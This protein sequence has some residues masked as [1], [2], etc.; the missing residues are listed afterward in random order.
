M[1]TTRTI[2]LSLTL[3]ASIGGASRNLDADTSVSTVIEVTKFRGMTL[4]DLQISPDGGE[5]AVVMGWGSSTKS[6]V[7]RIGTLN[8]DQTSADAS[9]E[10]GNIDTASERVVWTSQ[11]EIVVSANGSVV[12]VRREKDGWARKKSQLANASRI[13]VIDS[14]SMIICDN[15]ARTVRRVDTSKPGDVWRTQI[16]HDGSGGLSLDETGSRILVYSFM[17][18]KVSV[19]DAAT[20]SLLTSVRYTDELKP[21]A[22]AIVGKGTILSIDAVGRWACHDAAGAAIHDGRLQAE[23]LMVDGSAMRSWGSTFRC[24]F[25]NE[26]KTRVLNCSLKDGQI[27]Q[28]L[29]AE[30]DGKGVLADTT[31]ELTVVL[32]DQGSNMYSVVCMRAR[33]D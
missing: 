9:V 17:K 12:T 6:S 18:D 22:T 7:L 27:E 30:I 33:T 24:V 29:I 21:R 8:P 25:E 31:K 14:H 11:D 28:S 2:L 32:C 1:G 16:E 10:V 4:R 19:I 13:A 20:G 5:Y 3:A 23:G 15:A 26:S